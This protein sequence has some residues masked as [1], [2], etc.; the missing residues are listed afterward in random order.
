MLKI[1]YV[2]EAK[3]VIDELNC[4]LGKAAAIAKID[5]PEVVEEIIEIQRNN[6]MVSYSLNNETKIKREKVDFLETKEEEYRKIVGGFTG[7]ILQ[8]G[9]LLGAEIHIAR[10]VNRRLFR[11]VTYCSATGIDI[12]SVIFDY[13]NKLSS[14]LFTLSKYINH[15]LGVEEIKVYED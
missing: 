14:Y 11:Q 3:G 1:N 15:R 4:H 9:S 13:L 10:A 2:I 12:D 7:F 8:G 5:L 6:F